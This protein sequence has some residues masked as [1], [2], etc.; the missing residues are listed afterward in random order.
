MVQPWKKQ[1]VNKQTTFR[2]N[3]PISRQYILTT[4][5]GVNNYK[6]SNEDGAVL[7]KIRT[8]SKLVAG[9]NEYDLTRNHFI[10]L[11]GGTYNGPQQISYHLGTKTSSSDP[12]SLALITNLSSG[13]GKSTVNILL[14]LKFCTL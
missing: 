3:Y 11:A 4:F 9:S 8:D 6:F 2:Q 1:V 5:S 12:V 13:S 7:C 14:H 10:L